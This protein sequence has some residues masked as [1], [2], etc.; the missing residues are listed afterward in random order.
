VPLGQPGISSGRAAW[1][2]RFATP[3]YGFVFGNGL[4]V[5]TDGGKHWPAAA[6][7]G[8]SIVSLEVIDRQVLAV[9]M[10]RGMA[11]TRAGHSSGGLWPEGYGPGS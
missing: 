4:W 5:T 10:R 7:P 2:I 9:T 3:E 8:G 11:G 1:G 6:Y